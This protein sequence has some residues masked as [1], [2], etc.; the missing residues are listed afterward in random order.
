RAG[1]EERAE[2]LL[3]DLLAMGGEDACVARFERA[4]ARFDNGAADE[5]YAELDLLQREPALNDGHCTLVA[6]LL[7]EQDDLAGAL[8]WYD[9]GV[10]RLA[11]EEME[12]LRAA[13]G[14]LMSVFLLRDRRAIRQRLD[15][16]PD[17][18]DQL[19]PDRSRADDLNE[20]LERFEAEAPVHERAVLFF[21][22]G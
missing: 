19:I 14:Q 15:L 3:T 4:V 13:N 7:T 10:T 5:A 16:P 18:T 22:R 21:P 6:E 1:D 20:L 8:R 12:A 17:A 9:R 2:A 11:A